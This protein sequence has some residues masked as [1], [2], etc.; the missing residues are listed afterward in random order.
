MCSQ[1]CPLEHNIMRT[2]VRLS[3]TTALVRSGQDTPLEKDHDCSKE[4]LVPEFGS[5]P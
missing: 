2:V 5:K 3:D 1:Q 4:Y